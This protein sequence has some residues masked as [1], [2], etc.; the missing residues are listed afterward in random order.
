MEIPHWAVVKIG[1][2]LIMCSAQCS[3]QDGCCLDDDVIQVGTVEHRLILK[4]STCPHGAYSLDRIGVHEIFLS[5]GVI[6]A[7][8][9]THLVSA[10][11]LICTVVTHLSAADLKKPCHKVCFGKTKL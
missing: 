2:N 6:S 5:E 11:L 4:L 9:A 10:L 8:R 3:D 1:R 7:V